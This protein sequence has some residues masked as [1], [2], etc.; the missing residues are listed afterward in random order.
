MEE[1]LAL[2]S[3]ERTV[4]EV[5]LPAV[6]DLDDGEPQSPS[7]SSRGATARGGSPPRSA[8]RRP[9]IAMRAF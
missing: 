3:V 9:R 2:R 4:E 8:W 7:T 1:S 5:L 6:Q